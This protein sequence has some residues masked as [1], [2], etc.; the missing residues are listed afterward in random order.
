MGKLNLIINTKS[1]ILY[2]IML[3]NDLGRCL[4][5]IIVLFSK[6]C[7]PVTKE[8]NFLGYQSHSMTKIIV[9]QG[10]CVK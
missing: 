5:K 1:K 4:A 7:A 9:Y 2:D 10:F 3:R 8:M 6:I